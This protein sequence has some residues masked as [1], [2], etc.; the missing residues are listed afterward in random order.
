VDKRDRAPRSLR[1]PGSDPRRG[2]MGG[3]RLRLGGLFQEDAH[4][5]APTMKDAQ[6]LHLVAG[7]PIEDYVRFDNGTAD[8]RRYFFAA[9]T[10]FRPV[11]GAFAGPS[12][13]EEDTGRRSWT[14]D[15]DVLH[16]A[17]EVRDSL[18][19]EDVLAQLAAFFEPRPLL[20]EPRWVACFAFLRLSNSSN[21]SPPS[22]SSP[23][24]AC[25][26]PTPISRRN[27]SRCV[28]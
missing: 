14:F 7:V 25:S 1:Q 6:H 3:A 13:L 9:P 4:D 28:A 19:R 12:D 17:F 20:R 15:G 16:D 23:R 2:H 24:S 5:I 11:R 21:T 8:T 22:M 27:A 18:S 10:R 26:M